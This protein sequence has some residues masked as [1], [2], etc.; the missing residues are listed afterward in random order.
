MRTDPMGQA[1]HEAPSPD[2]KRVP[3]VL[4]PLYRLC[5]PRKRQAMRGAGWLD[6]LGPFPALLHDVRY[7]VDGEVECVD[8]LPA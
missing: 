6:G 4:Q 5:G 2:L 1:Y 3:R 7:W 8:S